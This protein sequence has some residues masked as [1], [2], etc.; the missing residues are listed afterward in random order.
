MEIKEAG[1][2]AGKLALLIIT[3]TV[4][5]LIVLGFLYWRKKKK[6]KLAEQISKSSEVKPVVEEKVETLKEPT[7]LDG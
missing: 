6:K 3:P 4:I 2:K 1:V 5:L 7:K